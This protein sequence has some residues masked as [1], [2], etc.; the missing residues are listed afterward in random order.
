MTYAALTAE[1]DH[2]LHEL[3]HG[4][5][6]VP[7]DELTRKVQR[8]YALIAEGRRLLREA[9][10]AVAHVI[11]DAAL[12]ADGAEEEEADDDNAADPESEEADDDA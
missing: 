7:L 1:L 10:D 8:C 11:E 9:E 6:D 4:D 3:E 2:L 12:P 5:T